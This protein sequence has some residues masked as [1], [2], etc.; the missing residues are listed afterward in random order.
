LITGT[1]LTPD[2][3]LRGGQVLVDATGKIACVDC[4]CSA[5]GASATKIVCP[6]GV[7]SPGLINTH[8]HITYTQNAPAP[9]TGERYEQRHDWRL[10]KRGPTKIPPTGSATSDQISWGELRFLMGG[11]TSTVGSG[12]AKGLLRN[13]DK[14]DQ[15]GLGHMPVDFETFPLGDSSG[16]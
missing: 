9:D 11:A 14:T 3:I 15:E 7:V 4:D 6:T 2:G 12:S 5:Q 10:G 8:D 13:L 1:I 16:T